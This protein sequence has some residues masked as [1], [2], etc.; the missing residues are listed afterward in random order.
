MKIGDLFLMEAP[1]GERVCFQFLGKDAEQLNSDVIRVFE[2]SCYREGS[3]SVSDCS[4]WNAAFHAHVFINVGNRK[5]L[6]RKI[7]NSP[8]D[9]LK[10][11]L[12]RI[13]GDYG[14]PE[15]TVSRDWAG[16]SFG[17]S[18]IDLGP[19]EGK[20]RDAEIGVVVTPEDVLERAMTG[21]YSFVHP[22]FD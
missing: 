14:N 12:F 13:S 8:V 4:D 17:S 18:M 10:E 16:W 19:L 2:P 1:T 22:G 7:G 5:K 9:E 6:W 21:S 3:I 15:I 20:W 11:V